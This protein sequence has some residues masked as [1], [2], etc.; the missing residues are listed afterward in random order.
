MQHYCID[1]FQLYFHLT[2]AL[3]HLYR[4]S[5]RDLHYLSSSS[6]AAINLALYPSL[7]FSH[8]MFTL[9]IK[10]HSHIKTQFAY[11]PINSYDFRVNLSPIELSWN[12]ITHFTSSPKELW[13]K[14]FTIFIQGHTSIDMGFYVQ[15]W[16]QWK[17]ILCAHV[18]GKSFFLQR[19]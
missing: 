18:V 16:W 10:G 17:G 7:S 11:C 19:V 14:C 15:D 12:S 4:Q 2:L 3:D 13:R 1:Y 5:F 6:A 9:I 8:T